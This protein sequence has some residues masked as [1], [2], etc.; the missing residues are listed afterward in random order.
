[1]SRSSAARVG[2]VLSALC[3]LSLLI[4]SPG[5]VNARQDQAVVDCVE[6]MM[7][8][9]NTE[10]DID[11]TAELV[12]EVVESCQE[13]V[14][15]GSDELLVGCFFEA[16]Q[17]DFEPRIAVVFQGFVSLC[18]Q[19]A[20]EAMA[21]APRDPQAIRSQLERELQAAALML[22]F[23]ELSNLRDTPAES[24]NPFVVGYQVGEREQVP[25]GIPQAIPI[26]FQPPGLVIFQGRWLMNPLPAGR[27]RT[28]E[29]VRAALAAREDPCGREN[30]RPAPYGDAS[31]IGS[32]ARPG[33]NDPNFSGDP[34]TGEAR[35]YIVSSCL[36]V[37]LSVGIAAF[38]PGSHGARNKP[39]VMESIRQSTERYA[40]QIGE[41]V[42]NVI[43]RTC[44][45]F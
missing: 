30:V 28:T 10:P 4:L 34:Y 22:P 25:L 37:D 23:W 13:V 19:G 8:L 41:T 20:V 29:E 38:P 31:C 44:G 27:L 14:R 33:A 39:E 24:I 36:D 6:R 35:I 17:L 18:R 21:P 26:T 15:L 45:G 2:R 42:W 3:L 40:L 16:L 11:V 7:Q 5:G 9:V 1:M 12:G 43:S 32:N